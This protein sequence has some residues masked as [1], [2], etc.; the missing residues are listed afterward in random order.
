MDQRHFEG[1]Q[2]TECFRILEE[3][4]F[5]IA[6]K[7]EY[8]LQ[9]KFDVGRLKEDLEKTG[10]LFVDKLLYRFVMALL[11][12]PFVMLTGL[13]GSGK[14]KL[15]QVFAQWIC[16]KSEQMCIVPVGRIR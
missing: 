14:T 15:A 3:N 2:G 11:A 12:K 8:Q 9:T 5:V 13:A 7:K 4:G 16:G 6:G 10:L 1:G